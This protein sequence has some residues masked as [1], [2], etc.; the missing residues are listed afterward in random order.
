MFE[1]LKEK[2]WANFQRIVNFLSKKLTLSSQNNGLGNP[3]SKIG[4]SN[5]NL[6]LI[7]DPEVKKAPD[8]DPDPQHCKISSQS[9]R[10]ASPPRTLT[11]CSGWTALCRPLPTCCG[12]SSSGSPLPLQ[13]RKAVRRQRR[14]RC[15][16]G[17][18]C[19]RRETD[20]RT[21]AAPHQE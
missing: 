12:C 16:I 7:P 10:T 8:P 4:D 15:P 14:R 5:K 6:F 13:E 18:G 20:E 9:C 11:A 21:V 2:I 17:G 3:G 19:T 1:M